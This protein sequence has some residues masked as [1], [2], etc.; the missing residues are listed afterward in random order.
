MR[1]NERSVISRRAWLLLL[2]FV[3]HSLTL[4]A[5]M[6]VPFLLLPA[7]MISLGL[8]MAMLAYWLKLPCPRCGRAVSNPRVLRSLMA[9]R[10]PHCAL[11]LHENWPK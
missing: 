2:W 11:Y 7:I 10:C 6:A 1:W 9:S 3:A 4:W 5:G 8:F